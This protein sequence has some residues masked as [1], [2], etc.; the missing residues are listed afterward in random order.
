MNAEEK[1]VIVVPLYRDWDSLEQLITSI[2]QI[3][4]SIWNK[5]KIIVVDDFSLQSIP[6]YLN[7]YKNKIEVVE[8]IRNLGHQKAISIGLCYAVSK[9]ANS[10]YFVIMDADGEDRPEDILDLLKLVKQFPEASAFAKR[11][12][13]SENNLFKTSYYLYKVFFKLLTGKKIDFG[14]FCVL[15]AESAARL[16]HVSEIWLHFSS[17]VIKAQIP[18]KTLP[19]KRGR[20]YLGNSKMNFTSLISHGLSA[21]AVYSE[22]VAVRITLIS[23]FASF[24]ALAGIIVLFVIKQFTTLA[25]PGWT[26]FVTLG[27]LILIAQFFSLGILLAFVILS[28]KTIKNIN[29]SKIFTEYIY[30]VYFEY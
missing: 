12:K 24:V 29:P 14:N 7:T 25:I 21:I 18:F 23:I 4:A 10:D 27:L 15:T 19:T 6:K 11:H 2:K 5:A 17:A 3:S 9:Y 22:I 30:K 16:V 28:A 13:R 1:I 8:L 26:S 20:R